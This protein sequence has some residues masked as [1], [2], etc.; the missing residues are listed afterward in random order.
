MARSR[1]ALTLAPSAR[2]SMQR[3]NSARFCA[4]VHLTSKIVR[5]EVGTET[6]DLAVR[7]FQDAHTFVRY[8][9]T[10]RT[11]PSRRP[12]QCRAAIADDDIAESRVHLAEAVPV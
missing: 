2:R 3:V 1:S 6:R 4:L 9:S 7:H 5:I 11:R 12:L 8:W 10:S